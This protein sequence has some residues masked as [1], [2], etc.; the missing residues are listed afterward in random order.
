MILGVSSGDMTDCCLVRTRIET[1]RMSSSPPRVHQECGDTQGPVI[2]ALGAS[3]VRPPDSILSVLR[4]E[5]LNK[6]LG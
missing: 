4:S 5:A 2:T 3:I 6:A 1:L